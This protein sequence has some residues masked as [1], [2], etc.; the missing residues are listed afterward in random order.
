[1]TAYLRGQGSVFLRRDDA[2]YL[3]MSS[4]KEQLMQQHLSPRN[5]RVIGDVVQGYQNPREDFNVF[6]LQDCC[7]SMTPC[8]S[9]GLKSSKKH[10]SSLCFSTFL[11]KSFTVP[12]TGSMLI[13]GDQ[14]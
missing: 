9:A 2:R 11:A 3:L 6:R 14:T 5:L 10:S 12:H 13:D 4:S 1:M 8:R 7:L